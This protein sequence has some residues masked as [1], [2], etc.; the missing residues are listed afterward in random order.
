MVLIDMVF[1]DIV[2]MDIVF[3]DIVFMD[4]VSIE[5]CYFQVLKLISRSTLPVIPST[6]PESEYC[7]MLN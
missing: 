2:F 7:H 6:L 1:M 5:L 4:M 3:M